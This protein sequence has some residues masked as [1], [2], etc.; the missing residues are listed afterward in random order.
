VSTT[1]DISGHLGLPQLPRLEDL[2]EATR[3]DQFVEQLSDQLLHS[4]ISKV[5]PSM[6]GLVRPSVL[7]DVSREHSTTFLAGLDR[8]FHYAQSD[9]RLE[10]QFRSYL[11]YCATVYVA[12]KH[13]AI[14]V[15][16][17]LGDLLKEHDGAVT[18]Q[19]S[20]LPGRS[21][22][23]GL[24]VT[25]DVPA[26]EVKY[27]IDQG[28]VD[29]FRRIGNAIDEANLIGMYED[30]HPD[31]NGTSAARLQRLRIGLPRRT[32]G[33]QIVDV[34]AFA[35]L[36]ADLTAG[37]GDSRGLRGVRI[38]VD[39]LL[40][41]LD[42][43]APQLV[44]S[45]ASSASS[46]NLA[47]IESFVA[48][49]PAGPLAAYMNSSG[50]SSAI[51]VCPA[52]LLRTGLGRDD[53]GS[54]NLLVSERPSDEAIEAIKGVASRLWGG[55]SQYRATLAA[56]A[57]INADLAEHVYAIGHPLK[58]RLGRLKGSLG[59]LR[60]FT[61]AEQT[62]KVRKGLTREFRR[63]EARLEA[64]E[65]TSKVMDL[66]AELTRRHGNPGAMDPEKDFLVTTPYPLLA[67]LRKTV[68]LLLP[69]VTIRYRN[70][71][72]LANAQILPTFPTTPKPTRFFDPF[73]DDVLFELVD[74][75][76]EKVHELSRYLDV[77][78]LRLTPDDTGTSAYSECIEFDNSIAA[79]FVPE[80]GDF[81]KRLGL[82][83]GQWSEWDTSVAGPKGGLRLLAFALK[84][85]H[86]KVWAR[87]EQQED[88]YWHFRVAIELPKVGGG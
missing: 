47:A 59:T 78:L 69:S 42:Q 51:Y 79:E 86:C 87:P 40:A 52:S 57:R 6:V 56:H 25:L 49:F 33:A 84:V 22:G 68:E 12:S 5:L 82:R 45:T 62:P 72:L 14:G 63:L 53:R 32:G 80:G 60:Q 37:D 46:S 74:N 8:V 73:F 41:H 50:T 65:N 15:S 83:P 58:R 27:I 70:E 4:T 61:G 26:M 13:H 44:K 28:T 11:G 88:T 19:A 67:K 71:A 55:I 31:S 36:V 21:G 64:A 75:A 85:I 35:R 39:D 29:R 34:D 54:L 66:M 20:L 10:T 9:S 77:G 43:S 48:R 23:M 81:K 76:A 3:Q 7:K 16:G 30:T 38:R 17:L 2:A 18:L 1:T 24:T